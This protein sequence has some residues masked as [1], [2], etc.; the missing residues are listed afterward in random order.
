MIEHRTNILTNLTK[1]ID[2][3]PS[4]YLNESAL[5]EDG[6]WATEA[7]IV[8]TANLLGHDIYTYSKYGDCMKWMNHPASLS[9]QNSTEYALYIDHVNSNHYDVV[10]SV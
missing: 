2:Y 5:I 8:A 1:F 9:L 10:I 4:N 3:N 6:T 7:E